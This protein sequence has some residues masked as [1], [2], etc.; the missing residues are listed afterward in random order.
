MDDLRKRILTAALPHAGFDGWTMAMLEQAARDLGLPKEEAHRAFPGGPTEAILYFSTEADRAMTETLARDYHLASMRLRERIAICVMT[1]L[2]HNTPHREAVRRAIAHMAQPWNAPS[3]MKSLYATVDAMWR[4]AGDTSV[5]FN[6]YT[7]RLT[8]ANVYSATLLVWLG[9][10]SPNL[11][12]TEA[13]LARRIENVMQFEKF[14]ARAK[15]TLG[16]AAS[17]LPNLARRRA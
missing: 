3:A 9:D 2:R 13:F 15:E 10:D 1:R 5:D 16:H 8:L 11:E 14:K 6:F 12:E 7:K 17:F 4:A